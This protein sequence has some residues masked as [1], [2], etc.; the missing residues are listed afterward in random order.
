M[1]L[2]E[3]HKNGAVDPFCKTSKHRKTAGHL[4]IHL[5]MRGDKEVKK[6]AEAITFIEI[7]NSTFAPVR[8][9]STLVPTINS[10][11]KYTGEFDLR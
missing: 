4:L 3:R 10:L 11:D 7:L 8:H 2:D 6:L 5:I 1:I 9:Y